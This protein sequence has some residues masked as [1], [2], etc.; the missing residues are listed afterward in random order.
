[1]TAIGTMEESGEFFYVHWREESLPEI[2]KNV[3]LDTVIRFFP[4]AN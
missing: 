3:F 2:D 4:A 1:M